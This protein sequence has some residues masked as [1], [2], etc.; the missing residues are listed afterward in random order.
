VEFLFSTDPGPSGNNAWD[1]A[2]WTRLR[3]SPAEGV[4][5]AGEGFPQAYNGEVGVYEVPNVLP[6]A[7]LFY[8]VEVAPERTAL[9][10]LKEPAFDIRQK[11]VVSEESLSPSARTALAPLV[12]AAP[13]PL[14]SAR[15]VLYESRRVQVEADADAPALLVLNDA[16]YPG[17]RAWVD[18]RPAP[19]LAADHLFRGVLV[20]TGRH[21][22]EFVY[23]PASFLWGLAVSLLAFLFLAGLW[24]SQSAHKAKTFPK[25]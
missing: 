22:V 14:A 18:G 6:R 7:A 25:S 8:A 10:R 12:G 4:T 13:R 20:P 11:A 19:I 17:W 1:W 3:F 16:D 2:G 21:V 9:A 15:I 5:V 23:Q 24:C